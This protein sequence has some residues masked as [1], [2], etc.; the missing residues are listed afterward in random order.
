MKKDKQNWLYDEEYIVGLETTNIPVIYILGCFTSKENAK[1]Y[2]D[3][4][5]SKIQ[6]MKRKDIKVSIE[7]IRNFKFKEWKEIIIMK[8]TLNKVDRLYPTIK[9]IINNKEYKI[10]VVTKFQMLGIL[11]EFESSL[12][13]IETIR[14]EKIMEYGK[15]NED[16]QIYVD[17]NDSEN[18]SKFIAEMNELMNTETDVNINPLDAKTVIN[19]GLSSDELMILYDIME[20]N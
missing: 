7:T 16:G 6:K 12:A 11:K 10:D 1:K 4:V 3:Y 20:L 19:I 8:M 5:K 9:N 18:F 15:T 17:K 13:N 2:K 14:N